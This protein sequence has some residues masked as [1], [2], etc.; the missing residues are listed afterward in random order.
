MINE[1]LYEDKKDKEIVRLKMLIERY[2]EYDK[3]R[4]EYYA[5]KMQRLGELES[6]LEEKQDTSTP[7]EVQVL[8]LKQEIKRLN[9]VITIPGIEDNRTQEELTEVIRADEY[10]RQNKQL[11]NRIKGLHDTISELAYKNQRLGQIL[12]KSNGNT[13]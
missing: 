13:D 1:D 5:K 10:R 2:K 3:E 4:K 12:A 11:R 6:L 8:Q 9:S 7:L